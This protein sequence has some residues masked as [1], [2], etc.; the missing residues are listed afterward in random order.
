MN[1]CSERLEPLAG[2]ASTRRYQR[3]W[4]H[5]GSH[6]IRVEYPPDDRDRLARDLRIAAW[7]A[8]RGLRLPRVQEVDL[9]RGCALLEDFGPDDAEVVLRR[10]PAS[11]RRGKVSELLQPLERLA[12]LHPGELPPWN[13]PLDSTRLRW[14]LAG[15]ELWWALYRR[16]SAP[17]PDTDAWLDSLATRVAAHPRR[18][19]HR[20]FHV[21][22]LYLLP[23]RTVGVIDAQDVMV[24]PDSYD[25]ASLLG[26]RALPELLASEQLAEC[27]DE[28]SHRTRAEPG[29]RQRF[30]EASLQ[31]GLKVMGTFARLVLSGRSRYE[32][33]LPSLAVSVGRLATDDGAPPD[34]VAL[35]LD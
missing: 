30:T 22:N 2:D 9:E 25:V 14:E 15:W 16:G 32:R 33:W 34:A 31:R 3:L 35:L 21:N 11:D 12:D 17:S 13:A 20:D 8:E 28:W 29:W 23:E 10:L 5:D 6:V 19:C 7:L 24:G 26:E 18:V 1:S 27:V 4:R